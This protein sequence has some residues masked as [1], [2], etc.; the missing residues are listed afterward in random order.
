MWAI[1]GGRVAI[2]AQALGIGHAAFDEALLHAKRRQTF[3]RPIGWYQAVDMATDLEA[4]RM[5]MYRG[6][7]AKDT[8][9]RSGVEAAM[10]KL[11]ASEAAHRTTD[12]A[13]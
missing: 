10:V 1:D 7:V 13:M 9:A 5:L 4:T 12:K 2:A 6:V 3:G 11:Y 8:Q